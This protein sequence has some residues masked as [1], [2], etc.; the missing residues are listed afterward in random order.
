MA[1]RMASVL[2]LLFVFA[3][4]LSGCGR[5][6]SG[7]IVIG[8]SGA[9]TT[10][11]SILGITQKNALEL[12]LEEINSKGGVLGREIQLLFE[13]DRA[14]PSRVATIGQKFATKDKVV[15]MIG[16]TNDG[17]GLVLARI[18]EENKI[19]L[20]IPF[21]NGDAIS[22]GRKYVFQLDTASSVMVDEVIRFMVQEQGWKKIAIVHDD[23]AFGEADRDFAAESL[24]KYGLQPVAVESLQP[25][26]QD[27]SPQLLR[28]K[29]G[30]A[31]AIF[32]PAAGTHLAQL[33]K[34]MKKV[35][36][37]IPAVGPNSL[38]FQSMIEVGGEFVEGV[39]FTDLIDETKPGVQEVQE[40]YE[41]KFGY[42]PKDGFVLE[43]Y[44]SLFLLVEAIKAAGSTDGTQIAQAIENLKGF[45]AISGRKDSVIEFSPTDHRRA[46]PTNLV[47]RV[48]KDGEFT[49]LGQ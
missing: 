35:N 9:L 17:T 29:E 30:G 14:D 25:G 31:D 43:A 8:V 13:D 19:P 12:A 4:V 11:E 26:G 3:L 7:P 22:Q 24:K 41:K 6:E 18:A 15:A 16:P 21:A 32:I 40:K 45:K 42:F 10:S 28:V 44:D 39:M 47:W 2:T 33:R 27:Y 48:V 46:D 37:V 38:A 36:W 49:N 5:K 34:D 23:N 1:R 20:V